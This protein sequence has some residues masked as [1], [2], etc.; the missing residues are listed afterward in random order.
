MRVELKES[1][2]LA[3]DYQE[4]ILPAV[5]RREELMRKSLRLINGINA[6]GMPVLVSEQYPKGLGKTV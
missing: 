2:L 3:V 6:L 4:K 5:Q 1:V